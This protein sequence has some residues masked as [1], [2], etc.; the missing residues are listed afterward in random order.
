MML[1]FRFAA[2]C[3]LGV[4]GATAGGVIFLFLRAA[5]EDWRKKRWNKR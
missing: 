2:G 4:V 3:L 1:F 5:T